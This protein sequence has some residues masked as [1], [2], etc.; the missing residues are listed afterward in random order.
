[1]NFLQAFIHRTWERREGTV[2]PHM[3]AFDPKETLATVR[4][5]RNAGQFDVR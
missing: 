2:A 4:A 5:K 3:S 1:M